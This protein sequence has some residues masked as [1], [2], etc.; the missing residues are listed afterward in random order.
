MR[1]LLLFAS[2][3]CFG[4]AF[5]N[6]RPDVAD[7]LRARDMDPAT[8]RFRTEDPFGGVLSQPQGLNKYAY[9]NQN[10]AAYGDPSGHWGFSLFGIQQDMG[11]WM[12]ARDRIRSG[13]SAAPASFS[14]VYN[15]FVGG[16]MLTALERRA[17]EKTQTAWAGMFQGAGEGAGDYL[18][19]LEGTANQGRTVRDPE[20]GDRV[21]AADQRYFRVAAAGL[22]DSSVERAVEAAQAA[23]TNLAR[24][25]RTNGVLDRT[26]GPRVDELNFWMESQYQAGLAK[27][28]LV[29]GDPLDGWTVGV[30]VYPSYT[31]RGAANT[32]GRGPSA[33][34]MRLLRPEM[35][36]SP[37]GFQQAV[38]RTR[39][40]GM[41]GLPPERTLSVLQRD[42][43]ALMFGL[44]VASRR[45]WRGR[46][47]T[48]AGR[49]GGSR[50]AWAR[51][52]SAA[53]TNGAGAT[54]CSRCGKP[55]TWC[56]AGLAWSAGR[57]PSHGWVRRGLEWR[58]EGSRPDP[59]W[60]SAGRRRWQCTRG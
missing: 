40:F 1:A 53:A 46:C 21:E 27:A 33:Q 45:A 41:S 35:G 36:T 56:R 54:T 4:N 50:K 58:R 39:Q 19:A 43:P 59:G 7:H 55:T 2:I 29:G 13:W 20:S 37:G 5:A 8:G 22:P 44:Y 42:Y 26:E 11:L 16:Q 23:T 47:R 57:G 18:G 9:A 24:R 30:E 31:H 15:G 60:R 28:W 48:P 6:N 3:W 17:P 34:A 51:A 14:A 52:R 38:N 12:M 10:P 49:S 32:A 25:V